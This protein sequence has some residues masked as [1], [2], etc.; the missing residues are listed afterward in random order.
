MHLMGRLNHDQR[1][2]FYSFRLED[3]VRDDHLVRAIAGVL[4]L[5]CTVYV[6]PNLVTSG[7]T[8]SL[9][10]AKAQ[11]LRN[12]QKCQQS[13][14]SVANRIGATESPLTETSKDFCNKICTNAKC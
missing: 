3:A 5:S 14:A 8:P 11:F 9:D 4:D 6:N 13:P 2:L 12:W 1:Q 10:E 7:R